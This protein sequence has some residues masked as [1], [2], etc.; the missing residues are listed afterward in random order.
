MRRLLVTVALIVLPPAG[1]LTISYMIVSRSAWVHQ[2]TQEVVA[3]QLAEMTGREVRLGRLKGNL[4]TNVEIDG[5]AVAADRSIGDGVVIAAR[6]VRM[7]YD[8]PAIL[9]RRSAPAA[10]IREVYVDGLEV[11]LIRY[12]DGQV[13]LQQLLPPPEVP[14]PI[15][16]QFQGQ[17]WIAD[18]RIHFTDHSSQFGQMPLH[19]ELRDLC[20]HADMRRVGLIRADLSATGD[21]NYFSTLKAEAVADVVDGSLSLDFDLDDLDLAWLQRRLLTASGVSVSSGTAQ[22]QGSVYRT[23]TEQTSA[24]GYS[25]KAHLAPTMMTVDGVPD[26]PVQLDGDLIVTPQGVSTHALRVGWDGQSLMVA[27][28]VVNFSQPT[29]DLE[30]QAAMVDVTRLVHMLPAKTR[31]DLPPFDVQGPVSL[32]AHVVGPAQHAAVDLHVRAAGTVTTEPTDELNVS[33]DGIDLTMALLDLSD[34]VLVGRVDMQSVR[35]APIPLGDTEDDSWP[36]HLT[37]SALHNVSAQLQ[38]ATGMPEIVS[39]LTIENAQLADTDFIS[40]SPIE[41]VA[42]DVAI[43]GGIPQMHTALAADEIRLW[44]VAVSNIRAEAALAGTAIHLRD[45]QAD[46]LNGKMTGEAVIDLSQ[47]TPAIYADGTIRDVQLEGLPAQRLGLDMPITGR[48]D[49]D[50]V[51]TYKGGQLSSAASVSGRELSYRQFQA[52]DAGALLTLEQDRLDMPAGFAVAPMGT[53]WAKGSLDSLRESSHS[54]LHAEV[55][56]AETHLGSLL[57]WFEIEDVGGVLYLQGTVSGTVASPHIEAEAT[58]FEP[59]YRQY[60][61]DALNADLTSDLRE[62]HVTQLLANRGSAAIA[63]SGSLTGLEKIR[64]PRSYTDIQIAGSFDGAGIRLAEMGDML[65]RKFDSLDGLAELQGVFGGTLDDPIATGQVKIAHAMTTTLDITEGFIPFELAGRI[66]EVED[67]LFHVQGSELYAQASIDLR[68]EPTMTA[69]LSAADIY[70]EGIY[71]LQ[72]MGLDIGGLVQMPVAKVSGPFDNL[73]GQA[74]LLS[75][76]IVVGDQEINNLQ[77]E[78]GLSKQLVK[79]L[80]M[81][82]HVADGQ[83]GAVGQY[84]LATGMMDADVA[85]SDAGVSRLLTVAKPVAAAVI[86]EQDFDRRQ[87]LLRTVDA[88]S[89]QLDG[90]LSGVIQVDGTIDEPVG[91]AQVQLV[92]A[93]FDRVSLPEIITT[94]TI[95]SEGLYDIALEATQGDALVT[96]EGDLE[97]DGD[98]SLLII[99]SGLDLADYDRWMPLQS[100][101]SGELGFTM[102]AAGNTRKPQIKASVDVIKPQV[103]GISFDVLNAPIILLEEGRLAIDTLTVRRSYER[104]LR[105][106]I[107]QTSEQ[108]IEPSSA[109]AEEEMVV[110]GALPFSWQPLG[111]V[112]DEPMSLEA[113]VEDTDLVLLPI[114]LHEF[115]Q[116]EARRDGTDAPDLWTRTSLGGRVDSVVQ[117]TGTPDKPELHGF[118]Q[119]QDALIGVGEHKDLL[120]SIALD[121]ELHSEDKG[122]TVLIKQADASWDSLRLG[123]SGSTTVTH[124]GVEKMAENSYD[125]VLTVAADRQQFA[126]GLIAWDVDGKATLKGDGQAAPELAIEELGGKLGKGHITVNGTAQIADFRLP[127]LAHNAMDI[128]V[129]ADR[130]ELALRGLVEGVLEGKISIAGPGD[131]TPAQIAGAYSLSH[132]RL[133]WPTGGDDQGELHAPGSR[134]PKP[135]LDVRLALGPD[136]QL[137]GPGIV[138]PLQPT[139]R[140]AH[141]H[142]TLQMPVIEGVVEAQRGRTQVPG[143][144][145][146]IKAMK[147]QYRLARKLEAIRREPVVLELTG[148]ISGQAE[149]IVRSASVHGRDIGSVLIEMKLSGN[150]PDQLRVDVSSNPPL[151]ESQIYA[152]LGA[153]PFSY[154]LGGSSTGGLDLEHLVSEQFLGALAAGFRVA[155]F[156]PLEQELRRLLGLSEFSLH[157]AFNQPVEVRL[158]KYL[159]EELL[160]TYQRAIGTGDDKYDLTVSYEVG[161]DWRVSYN[162]D[163]TGRHRMQLERVWSF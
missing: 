78:L 2:R 76:R 90:R 77:A 29:L 99:G 86:S 23:P 124:T 129:V 157:F 69:S 13:N 50:F 159:L 45:L 133:G 37:L 146:I 154:F 27:G 92:D 6:R 52:H 9:K 126:R 59:C 87:S 30:V 147:V 4:L 114:L 18:A 96:A 150:L 95:D 141:V 75:D 98:V 36:D 25:V 156:E 144:V 17:I 100:A 74:L 64:E 149:T 16:D 24:T 44:D 35:P 105:S 93:V 8:L 60:Q 21:D 121:I 118:L 51:L 88:M 112:S 94:A 135:R 58:V 12:S 123:L 97:Y 125:L 115:A 138:A 28:A 113:R 102:V 61:L 56:V 33:A 85:L 108:E 57:D 72:E 122:N 130:A 54:A 80:H 117:M 103:A 152:L 151:Q 38:W 106:D 70:L 83:M 143:G 55:Q 19:L 31:A 155:V 43:T 139:S 137:V 42:V 34:P 91:N 153:Q 119:V 127:Y 136:M 63:A 26:G 73:S 1:L 158:G 128:T 3:R 5:L 162:T 84:D 20:G 142:G 62:L 107:G 104:K 49:A 145:A 120:K 140:A 132:G 131:G 66:I 161:R 82:C 39:S 71:Q 22:V 89:L 110:D 163:E 7:S 32:Q 67:A 53:V 40:A 68:Y 116:Y 14:A 79:L 160:V 101:I 10:A 47:K 48:V 65:G 41:D 134:Y 111:I 15:E 148:D 109:H 11:D 81:Q 46:V